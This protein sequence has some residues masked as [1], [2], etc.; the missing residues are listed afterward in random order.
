MKRSFGLALALALFSLPVFAAKQPAT[1]TIPTPVQIGSTKVPAGDYKLTWTGSGAN[2]QGTLSRKD[3]AVATFAA[4]EI[5]EKGYAAV[6]TLSKGGAS[7]LRAIQLNDLRFEL[8]DATQS[9]M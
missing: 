2:V 7:I 5:D 9:G 3:K 8:Q 1:V 4:K 6:E